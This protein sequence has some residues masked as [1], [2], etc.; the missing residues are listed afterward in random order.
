MASVKVD[1]PLTIPRSKQDLSDNVVRI[2]LC[3]LGWL[4]LYIFMGVLSKILIPQVRTL[5]PKEQMFWQLAW[6]R[7]VCGTLVAWAVYLTFVDDRLD[8]DHVLATT[9]A[10][11]TFICVLTGFFIFEEATLIYF[12]VRFRTFSKELHLH[13]LFAFNG[14]FFAAWYNSGHYYAAK[15]FILEASTI[16]SCICWCL[17]KL[18]LEKTTVWKINQMILIHI[19]HLRS[20]YEMWWWYDI[21]RDWA[22]IKENLA[23]AYTVNMML[24]FAVV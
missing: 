16:S 18:K 22:N 1:I 10:S 14:F 24:G 9:D 15:A 4:V 6:V 2:G 20:V 3:F 8:R 12:D 17:L 13:H 7:A 23:I 19:F 5:K 21:Y 11:W